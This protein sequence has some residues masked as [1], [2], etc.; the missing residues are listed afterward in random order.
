MIRLAIL[1]CGGM[2]AEHVRRIKKRNE[3]QNGVE[4]VGL[5]DVDE[6]RVLVWRRKNIG[7]DSTAPIFTDAAQMY[8]ASKPDAVIIGTPHTPHTPH[9]LH[10]EH[11]QQALEAGL[12]VLM[13]KPMVTNSDDAA[14]GI[15]SYHRGLK[16]CCGVERAQ[17]R[18]G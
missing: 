9:T 5:C 2:A 10:F 15:E 11:G 14:W 18:S 7:D 6:D 12:H 17:M 4:I 13:E 3:T 8:A 16:Q 1:D